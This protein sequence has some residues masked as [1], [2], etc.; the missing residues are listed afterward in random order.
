MYMKV[1]IYIV[2][3]H[4]EYCVYSTKGMYIDTS[5]IIGTNVHTH[6]HSKEGCVAPGLY[7]GGRTNGSSIQG[8]CAC[9]T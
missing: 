4:I 1:C 2:H 8:I 7:V 9:G 5:T 6:L 3:V